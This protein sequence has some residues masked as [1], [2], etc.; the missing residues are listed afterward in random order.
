MP[1]HL[2]ACI[3][4]HGYGHFA[5]T[6]PILD[7]LSKSNNVAL[8][9]RCELPEVLIRSRVQGDFQLIPESSDFGML[10]N[11]SLDVDLAKSLSAYKKLHVRLA[12]A[13]KEESQKLKSYKA[14][15]ILANIPYVSI[16]AANALNIPVIA[17]CSLNWAEIFKSYYDKDSSE[18]NKIYEEMNEAYNMAHYF[19]CPAPSM[20][21]PGL[22]NI[23]N[24]GPIA[25]TGVNLRQNLEKRFQIHNKK[26]V[27]ISP[28]GVATPIEINDWPRSPDIVWI[29][30]WS[31]P[32]KRKDILSIES[33]DVSFCDLLK[34][35]DAL[36][37]KPGYGTVT[38]SAC[39]GT[40]ALYV[41]RGDWAEE[42]YLVSWWK[43]NANVLEIS[44]TDFFEG[45]VLHSLEKLWKL[46][47]REHISPSGINESVSYINS[48]R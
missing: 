21:M 46:P 38:E 12:F 17:Y 3:S 1:F 31:Y 39:N 15:L 8:S 30:A 11:N 2:L 22:K 14:D 37:T 5:M 23:R 36:I 6:A 27:L 20:K 19:L 24:I 33:L 18:A 9:I 29:T 26:L 41:L 25:R 43:K 16:A 10:M 13:I 40:P 4:S 45:N 35:C 32:S 34:T 7:K 47:N 44:R 28:G 48:Y 42:P